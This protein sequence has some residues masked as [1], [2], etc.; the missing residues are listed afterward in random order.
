MRV[1]KM[2]LLS[3]G[4]LLLLM[5]AW[6]PLSRGAQPPPYTRLISRTA[7]S[8]VGN[9]FSDAPSVSANGRFVVFESAAS[10]LVADDTNGFTDIFFYDRVLELMIRVSVATGGTEAMTGDSTNPSIS[11]DGRYIV[12]DSMASDLVANDTNG[13]SDIFLYDR[14]TQITTRVNLGAGGVQ[15]TGGNSTDPHLSQNADRIVYVSEASNLISGDGNTYADVYMYTRA[16]GVTQRVS[17]PNSAPNADPNGASITPYITSNGRYVTF[18]SVASNLVATDDN[19][20]CG[21]FSCSDIFVRDLNAN[22][23]TL[24]SL[25]TNE[26]QGDKASSRSVISDD[27]RYVVYES[28]ADNMDTTTPDTNAV[29]DVY[30]RDITAGTTIR[31]SKSQS[32]EEGIFASREPYISQ[33]GNW[34]SFST[35]SSFVAGDT[36]FTEDIYRYSR[37]STGLEV[38]SVPEAGGESNGSSRG[39]VLSSDGQRVGFWSEATNLTENDDNNNRDVFVRTYLEDDATPTPTSTPTNTSTPSSTPTASNTPTV[40]RTPT[41]T[42]T[43]T[44]CNGCPPTFTPTPGGPPVPTFTRTPTRTGTPG[45]GYVPGMY[46]P[47]IQKK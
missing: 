47:I 10:D 35:G 26:A 45:G 23:T 31:V 15:A 11:P 40:T 2:G 1:L 37:Q 6:A 34:V 5:T 41:V 13:L 33:D 4:V 32:G 25:N 38:A 28:E 36:N 17:V 27:G 22:T 30:L 24:V 21:I 18:A 19:D 20:F 43:G 39:A 29:S 3:T 9:D 44:V 42:V 14:Q 12:Y 46:L 7:D 16:S 8:E